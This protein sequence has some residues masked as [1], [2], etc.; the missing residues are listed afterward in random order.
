MVT[1]DQSQDGKTVTVRVGET[2]SVQ[3]PE[4]PTTGYRWHLQPIAD[5]ALHLSQDEFAGRQ[6]GYGAG[7]TRH[8]TFQVGRPTTATLEFELRPPGGQTPEQVFRVTVVAA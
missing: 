7:G 2:F 3:V 5:S 6:T 4:N 8:W 1:I